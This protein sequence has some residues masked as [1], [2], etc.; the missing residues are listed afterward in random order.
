MAAQDD[1]APEDI[2]CDDEVFDIDFHPTH[3]MVAVGSVSGV[4]QV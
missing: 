2:F 3:D 4:V 1:H